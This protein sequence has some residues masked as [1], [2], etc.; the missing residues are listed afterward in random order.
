MVI[1]YGFYNVVLSCIGCLLLGVL[2]PPWWNSD[3][4]Q[5]GIGTIRDAVERNGKRH[6]DVQQVTEPARWVMAGKTVRYAAVVTSVALGLAL[7]LLQFGAPHKIVAFVAVAAGAVAL[8]STIV[9]V[10]LRPDLGP[11]RPGLGLIAMFIGAPLSVMQA[12]WL[13]RL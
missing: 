2:G 11:L 4:R 13:A 3:R 12:L 10:A 6:W 7:L 9:F 5:V 8:V 1:R